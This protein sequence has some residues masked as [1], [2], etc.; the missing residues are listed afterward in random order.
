MLDAFLKRHATT[1][2]R[3]PTGS[4]DEV[5]DVAVKVAARWNGDA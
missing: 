2:D 5:K 4:L 1:E 3:G